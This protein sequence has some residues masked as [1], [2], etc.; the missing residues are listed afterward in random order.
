[1]EPGNGKLVSI[2]E[3]Q[4]SSFPPMAGVFL[5]NPGKIYAHHQLNKD[6]RQYV[7]QHPMFLLQ[8]VIAYNNNNS[9]S[10]SHSMLILREACSKIILDW[11]FFLTQI[12]YVY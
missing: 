9:S 2:Q 8:Y 6:F 4:Q 11:V 3:L 5:L 10:S 12:I 7:G 1:M